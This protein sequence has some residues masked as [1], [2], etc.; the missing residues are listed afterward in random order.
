MCTIVSA[1][2]DINRDKN[3]DG[4]S[5]EEYKEWIK[6][7]LQLNCNLFIITE[8]K[9]KDFFLTYRPKS[10]M[11]KTHIHIIDFKESFYYKYYNNIKQILESDYYKNKIKDPNRV[12]CKMPEYNIIQYSKFYYLKVA[13]ELN[14]FKTDYFLWADAGI[15]R[16]FLDVNLNIEYPSKNGL[17][18][19]KSNHDKFIIQNRFDIDYYNI[20]D[21]FIWKS[22]N[23]LYGTMFGGTSYIINIISELINNIFIN[24]M[25]AN[26]NVNNEQLALALVYNSN[27]HL[28]NLVNNCTY[29]HLI[30]FKYLAL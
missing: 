4:R 29:N 8:E 30:L 22:D 10:L 6:L 25:L 9:F 27:K 24:Q 17:S 23:L 7:T 26:N 14:I 16:F 2:F 15:S 11:S 21:S 20:D 1:F 19:L 3:G 13:I 18:V 12:E 5:I 28:F